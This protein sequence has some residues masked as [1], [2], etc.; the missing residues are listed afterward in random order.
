MM[1]EKKIKKVWSYFLAVAFIF[2]SLSLN[3]QSEAGE[4]K[5]VDSVFATLDV[6]NKITQL[7]MVPAYPTGNKEHYE[8]LEE[9]IEE[10]NIGGIVFMEGGPVAQVKLTNFLQEKSRIPLLIG[11][12]AEWGLG[13]NLDSTISFPLAMGL[14]ALRDDSLI[15][16]AARS[17]GQ[18]LQTLGVHMNF[19]PVVDINTDPKNPVIGMRA[20]S[21]D[22][23]IVLQKAKLYSQGLKD[24]GIMPVIKHFPG[25]GNVEIDPHLGLP[26]L[27]ASKSVINQRELY[28]F[29][30]LA[31][32][33][34]PGIMVGHLYAPNI[35]N[36][37]LPA[38]LSPAFIKG[39][40]RNGWNYEGLIISDA[41]NSSAIAANFNKGQPEEFAL[42]A[43]NDILLFP[44]NIPAAIRRIRRAVKRD[45]KIE[46]QLD[47]SVKRILKA[48]YRAGLAGSLSRDTTN[49]V[50]KLNA[51]DVQILKRK[52]TLNSITLAKKEDDLLP[53]AL[54]G[55]RNFAVLT[56]GADSENVSTF[57]KYLNKYTSFTAYNYEETST[58]EVF[59]KLGL[60]DVVVVGIFSTNIQEQELRKLEILNSSTNLIVAVFGSPYGL[61][62]LENLNNI[63]WVPDQTSLSQQLLPQLIFGAEEF[64]GQLPVTV[65][66]FQRGTGI[67]TE[68]INRLSFSIPEDAGIDGD[69]LKRI[70]EI[71]KEAIINRS[72]PGCQVLIARNG[73]VIWEKG[74]GF[75]SYDSLIP[76]DDFTIYD[77]AS[78]TK[79]A[80]SVQALM[81]LY[82]RGIIDLDKKIS[83]YLPG[84]EGTNKEN[85][86][87]RDILTHQAGLWPYLPF[88]KATMVGNEHLSQYYRPQREEEF[89]YQVGTSLFAVE[90][91]RDSVW[92]WIKESKVRAKE[93]REPY[94]YRY[95]DLGF[96][97]VHR[98]V[99]HLMNQP[100]EDFLNQ[101]LYD[102]VGMTTTGYH[103]LCSF[104]L[105]SIAPTEVDDYFRFELIYGLVHDQGAALMGGVAGHAGVFSNSLDLAKL[106]QLM[107]KSGSYGGKQYYKPETIEKFTSQ[108]YVTNRRGLGW[109][110][111]LT[112]EFGS[113]TS[114]YA[115]GSTF[116]HT[117]FTGTAIW[118]DPE[119]DLVYVF[120][121]NRIHPD[122]MNTKL[123]ST[124]VR[125]RIQDVIYKA[126]FRKIQYKEVQ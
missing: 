5:W 55:N 49:I 12:D 71:A 86:I 104:P 74:Y 58:P 115:S 19:A 47:A 37:G 110:K 98:L 50:S 87:L 10:Y 61:E 103:P 44:E 36:D 34:I 112:N 93:P 85:M 92:Q 116:G 6:E 126:M 54:L 114:R 102:P 83:Y 20:F 76:V 7:M 22:A 33:N 63:I 23:E 13:A 120:L 30:N 32:D 66:T 29:R 64:K 56:I 52:L 109:D 91:V 8:A 43:G 59:E 100:M 96:Y 70:D 60:Y 45:R 38:S 18:Q 16:E 17:I 62:K 101:N 105:T 118:A 123:I 67:I 75:H 26:V 125:T 88:H 11:M 111:P 35:I 51:P 53:V 108:Q 4:A 48:K 39:I 121:S 41:L 40:I 2:L 14:G 106:M 97:I 42:N 77:L 117:G 89:Q 1:N 65:G 24:A 113:P 9:L 73:K 81:F 46:K 90:S 25:H 31:E 99:E 57:D 27:K 107:L 95:S 28:P 94:D 72:T 84:L 3:A 68:G 119:F 15:Y 79:V 78:I 80:A 82:D 21:D 124:N 69:Y 122:A